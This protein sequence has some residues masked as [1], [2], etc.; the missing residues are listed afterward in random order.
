M[1][2]V[3]VDPLLG[4]PFRQFIGPQARS[5]EDECLFIRNLREFLKQDI[6]LVGIANQNGPL[7]DSVN[8]FAGMRRAD[9]DRI[10]EK[11][12]GKCLHFHRHCRRKENCLCCFRKRLENAF[13]RR[14][15]TEIDHLVAFIK[16]KMLNLPEID[17]SLRLKV[18][19]PTRRGDDDVDTLFQRTNLEIIA[20]TAADRQITHL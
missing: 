6:P 16:H 18:F 12:F 17:L 3:G 7:A 2:C 1:Q 19:E 11:G 8:R 9:G 10:A 13:D 14:Q 5:D 4:Q 15:E 20:F